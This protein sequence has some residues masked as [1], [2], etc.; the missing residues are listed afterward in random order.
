MPVRASVA[1]HSCALPLDVWPPPP[2]S[3]LPATAERAPDRFLPGCPAASR[4]SAA[5][6]PLGCRV[7]SASAAPRLVRHQEC[8]RRPKG[9]RAQSVRHKYEIGARRQS[10]QPCHL[11]H[12]ASSGAPNVPCGLSL[13]PSYQ[14]ACAWI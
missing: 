6:P 1:V 12:Q 7:S 4:R 8:R 14:S 9:D 10:G 11:K 2:P 3:T 5:E 13:H